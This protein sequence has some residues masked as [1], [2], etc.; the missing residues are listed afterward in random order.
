MR[1]R[2]RRPTNPDPR[3]A[4]PPSEAKP[5]F[6]LATAAGNKGGATSKTENMP[7]DEASLI[8]MRKAQLDEPEFRGA[9]VTRF[10]WTRRMRSEFNKTSATQRITEIME[11]AKDV[12]LNAIVFQVRGEATTLYP[13]KLEPW[14]ELV[15]G[16]DP[17]FDPVKFAIDEAHKRGLEFHA[18]INPIPCSEE[19]TT[20]PANR[21]HIFYKHCTPDSSPNWL[22]HRDGKVAPFNEYKWFNPNLPEVQ[23]YLRKVIMDFVRRYD[24]DGVHYDRIR[25]PS[26]TVSDDKW[27]KERYENANPMNLDYNEWQTDNISRFLT[28]LYGEIMEIKPK[29]KVSSAVWGIYDNTKLPQGNDRN[30]GY[31]W[32]SSGLQNYMQD[33]IGW[34]N[35]GCMDALIPMIYWNMGDRKPDYDELLLTF[36]DGIKNGRH[37]Y[38]GQRV[39][40]R[41]EMLRQVVATRILGGKGT[42][43]FT[44]GRIMRGDMREFY[45]TV[46]YPKPVPAPD[47]PWKSEPDTGILLVAVEDSAA[48]PV[49]D[50]EVRLKGD[51][52]VYLS[53]ADGF[54]SILLVPPGKAELTAEKKDAGAASATAEVTAGK[55]TRV[56]ITLTP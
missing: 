41:A 37:V 23:L 39:F 13:S 49:I 30:I 31:S 29:I 15:G 1:R 38:G 51:D 46:I 6:V 2:G 10:D 3:R 5:G 55:T 26:H 33:S 18:Y 53:A 4:G 12:G 50:A 54:C 34:A 22:V 19:R 32:T 27:S 43:P 56:K 35:R 40:D 20:T 14:S 28:D 9:W 24:V 45:K 44:L 17:G 11:G 8:E 7:L 48:N 21:D 25:F 36:V 42:C 16:K 47:M 52:Y